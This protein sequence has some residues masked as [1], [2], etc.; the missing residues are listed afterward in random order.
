MAR[1]KI[2][3]IFSGT[4]DFSV[5]FLEALFNDADFEILGVVTQTDKPAG[6]KRVLT[7]PP[8][9]V[10]A[11]ELGLPVYQPEKITELTDKIKGID[12]FI[13]VA[14]GKII[15]Q[16]ILSL[17]KYGCVN[18]HP[19]LLPRFR[20][21]TPIQ[22]AIIY[23]D[24]QSGVTI[25]VMDAGLD[26][27]PVLGQNIVRIEATDNY[28]SLFD[29]LTKAGLEIFTP[30]IKDYVSG[31]IKPRPQKEEGVVYVGQLKKEDGLIDWSKPAEEIERLVRAYNPWPGAFTKTGDITLK[32]IEAEVLDIEIKKAAGTIYEDDSGLAIKCGQGALKI[33]KIQPEGKK[34]MSAKEF[35]NGY[36][37]LINSVLK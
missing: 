27:G 24:K 22:S 29:K 12:V 31:K 28:G 18:V 17:P 34:P 8:V 36:G 19:S 2:R 20:G 10:R 7:S 35:L 4:P 13:D 26:T 6:R 37:R 1:E 23:G 16:S 15:P 5:P 30:T 25:M 11:E 32:I 14:Y 21:A 3:A 9:K 33:D